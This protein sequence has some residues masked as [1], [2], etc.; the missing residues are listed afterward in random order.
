MVRTFDGRLLTQRLK[1][2]LDS[3]SEPYT[4]GLSGGLDSSFLFYLSGKQCEP[5]VV[6]V[7]GARDITHAKIVAEHYKKHL[8][9]EVF[10]ESEIVEAA[11]LVLR[12]DPNS[13]FMEISYDAVLAGLMQRS[14]RD[15]I[16]TGQGSDEIFYGYSKFMDGRESSNDES[17]RI[18]R[19]RTVPRE[20]KLASI[21]EKEL[22][23]PYL[24][25]DIIDSFAGLTRTMHISEGVGK[26]ILRNTALEAGFEK[27]FTESKK[28]AAQY[29]SG[30]KRIIASAIKSGIIG[31]TE[32]ISGDL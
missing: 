4:L 5:C 10:S 28:L 32:R 19:E 24:H 8:K 18:L 7:D 2:S 12:A 16:V 3:I 9:I 29:G 20:M 1:D 15:F 21:M 11:S 26:L 13:S 25:R 14:E 17:L 22:V 30:F 31:N 27:K 23:T 6:G